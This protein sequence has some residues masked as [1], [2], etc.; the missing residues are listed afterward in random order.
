MGIVVESCKS[1]MVCCNDEDPKIVTEPNNLS[2]SL[3]MSDDKDSNNEYET[4]DLNKNIE[5]S[6]DIQNMKVKLND[7]VMDHQS[8]PW[9]YYKPLLNLGSGSYGT[10]VKVSL[11]KNPTN[12]IGIN[13]I[14]NITYIFVLSK[15]A[16]ILSPYNFFLN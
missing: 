9:I 8:S 3:S 13:T 11:I 4:E 16:N 6:N 15:L 14:S 7:L 10:V 5:F 2:D 1:H 12:I